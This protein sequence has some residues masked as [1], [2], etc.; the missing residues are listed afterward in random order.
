[1]KTTGKQG[2]PVY[3]QEP[4]TM[5]S[6]PARR[7]LAENLKALMESSKD[8]GGIVALEQATITRG[9]KIGKSTIDRILKET[10]PVNL[11]YVETLAKVFGLAPWQMLVPGLKPANP[12]ILRSTGA[13]EDELYRRIA[14]LAQHIAQRPKEPEEEP[15]PSSGRGMAKPLQDHPTPRRESRRHK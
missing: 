1:M 2:V 4:W 8:F 7:V 3:D 13:D 12:Q 9:G 11:D 6:P 15:A 14:E 10:T 5:T